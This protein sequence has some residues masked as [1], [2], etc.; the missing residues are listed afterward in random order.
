[1]RLCFTLKNEMTS[2]ILC[3]AK[4]AG[5]SLT[6]LPIP[7]TC[8]CTSCRAILPQDLK[9]GKGILIYSAIK[10]NHPKH[11]LHD[12][13]SFDLAKKYA[14][15]EIFPPDCPH[16]ILTEEYR[17]AIQHQSLVLKKI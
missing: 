5:Q 6:Y 11:P 13:I 12:N 7:T 16:P 4:L 17:N 3:T 2:H 1:M 10:Q 8:G 15:V 14:R 9:E